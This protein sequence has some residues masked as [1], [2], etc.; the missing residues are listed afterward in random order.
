MELEAHGFRFVE[1]VYTPRLDA[2]AGIGQ[3]R[4]PIQVSE[5]TVDDMAAI[6]AIAAAAFTTGRYLLDHRLAPDVN[7]RRYVTW[8]RSA[9]GSSGQTVLKAELDG[10]LV[11]FFVIEERPDHGVYWHLTAMAPT[12]QGR[13]I[14]RSVWETMLQ[15]HGRDGHR[16]VET[17]ISGHNLA[18]MNLYARL[19]FRFSGARLTFHRLVSAPA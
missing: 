8:V 5:A 10:E 16:W 13:G 6:E 1:T 15:R 19:G 14:G 3:P 17:T 2:L 9:A 11:G 12:A 7:G 4:H 18:V